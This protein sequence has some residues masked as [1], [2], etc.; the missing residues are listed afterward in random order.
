MG[1]VHVL[2]RRRGRQRAELLTPHGDGSLGLRL[3]VRH[4]NEWGAGDCFLMS[5]PPSEFRFVVLSERLPIVACGDP[6]QNAPDIG[7]V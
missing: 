1:M 3:H 6:F 4:Q 7:I 2:R 5:Q